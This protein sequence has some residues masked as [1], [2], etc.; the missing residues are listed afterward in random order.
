MDLKILELKDWSNL[1]NKPKKIQDM[2]MYTW[3]KW[4]KSSLLIQ[5]KTQKQERPRS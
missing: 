3:T 2:H 1:L 5:L 4:I